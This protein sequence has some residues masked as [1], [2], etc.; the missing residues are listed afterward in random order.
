M[1]YKK[2]MPLIVMILSMLCM[3][4]CG[5]Q[6]PDSNLA[7]A[8]ARVV[9]IT[10]STVSSYWKTT[11]AGAKAAG[12]EYNLDISFMGPDNE[13]D[14]ESQ[15]EMIRQAVKDGAKAIVFSA[16]DY[17]A[18]AEV[19]NE[20]I[21]QGVKVINIDSAVN[22]EK[23]SCYI[24]TDNYKAGEMVGQALLE[25][26]SEKLKVG[27]VNFAAVTDNGQR[28]EN[29]FRDFV[30]DSERVELVAS[31]NVNSTT[32]EAKAGTLKLLREYPQINAIVTFNEWTSLGVGY[33]IQELNLSDRTHVVAFDSNVV[34][35][36]MLETGEVDALIVQN[37][38]AIGYLGVE[39][40][41]KLINGEILKEKVINT[42]T[43][44]ITRKN[45]FEPENQKVLFSFD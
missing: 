14:Y 32:E 17:N 39:Y 2:T 18:N 44:L 26:S 19:V 3:S 12:A 27:I 13:E 31:I 36:D 30:T 28:R 35:V 34:S 5:M 6:N 15:N 7:D 10:K 42:T 11:F 40:A 9:V 41:V 25:S 1:K 43:T 8:K 24:S 45:M 33:A 4:A 16:V 22:S 37:P 23:V 29:G 20:A 38:Y 21:A